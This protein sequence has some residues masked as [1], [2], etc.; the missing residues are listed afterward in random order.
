VGSGAGK[1][2]LNATLGTAGS[3]SSCGALA[4]CLT[5]GSSSGVTG[6]VVHDV[7]SA[8]AAGPNTVG[9]LIV[10]GSSSAANFVLDPSSPNYNPQTHMLDEGL[11]SYTLGYNAS[12]RQERLYGL[13]DVAAFDLPTLITAAQNI[14]YAAEPWQDRQTEFLSQ[15]ASRASSREGPQLWLKA[16][17][18]ETQRTA[19]ASFAIPGV[20]TFQFST[21][22]RQETGGLIGG[23]DVGGQPRLLAGDSFLAGVAVGYVA[24]HVSYSHEPIQ[25]DYSGAVVALYGS[26]AS[27]A[28]F[29]DAVLNTNLLQA[30]YEK[31]GLAGFSA[32]PDVTAI[33]GSI[34][35]GRRWTLT[36][37]YY[38]E[39]IA[40]L[41]Y[42]SADLQSSAIAGAAVD[43]GA[44]S[45]GQ[46]SGRGGVGLRFGAQPASF[47]GGALIDWSVTARAWDEFAAANKAAVAVG[48]SDMTFE[49]R[50][51]GAFGEVAGRLGFQS[52]DGRWLGG[53]DAGVTFKDGFTSETVVAMVRYNW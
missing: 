37:A 31:A 22:Y 21:S 33:G 36:P 32:K 27:R 49:D 48:A 28:L 50:F 34:D 5:V 53:V 2:I 13:P 1:L 3:G 6:L 7:A 26:Y 29:I 10:N 16:V 47:G 18:D 4:D 11:F 39:P 25:A 30:K 40:T 38:V 43:F 45:S 46:D 42:V 9:V 17:G 14:W 51:A 35:V 12:T 24:S 20:S 52:P 19:S 15:A 44:G 41:T 8:G 23:V